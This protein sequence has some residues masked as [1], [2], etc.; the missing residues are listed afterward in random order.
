MGP[1]L[2]CGP[3]DPSHPDQVVT[4][5]RP[6]GSDAAR[7]GD[8][9]P[10][11]RGS[12][13]H[14]HHRTDRPDCHPPGRHAHHRTGRPDCHP[15][16]RV[17]SDRS[18]I[19]AAPTAR[20][21]TSPCE[22]QLLVARRLGTR[23]PEGDRNVTTP[24]DWNHRSHVPG[25]SRRDRHPGRNARSARNPS[26]TTPHAMNHHP[27]NWNDHGTTSRSSEG[28]SLPCWRDVADHRVRAAR[29]HRVG[30]TRRL[31][32]S[33]VLVE[34]G[35]Y[36][37][38]GP[39]PQSRRASRAIT[40]VRQS[41][42]IGPDAPEER[43]GHLSSGYEIRR[44]PTLPGTLVPSTI[45]AGGLNFRVRDGNGCDPSAVATEICCQLAR[46]TA[47]RGLHSEHELLR[48]RIPSPR[49]ISTGQLS[50][51]LRLHFRPINVV[52]YHG[53]YQVDP[54]GGIILKRASR[55]DA[56]SGYPVRRSPTSRALGRTTGTRE[57]RPSRSSR[58]RD[59]FPQSTFGCR[60]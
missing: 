28:W 4:R 13:R 2:R 15:P 20:T 31:R 60:G 53:P 26:A 1:G 44:R 17:R 38:D 54:V 58:T 12:G 40:P 36:P 43:C 3:D 39:E 55:L 49:P 32:R 34:A 33:W 9:N 25:R 52:V 27:T 37:P 10:S 42:R 35:P 45:G 29:R 59:S 57:L 51:L 16:G 48:G 19:D 50:A 41:S 7:C 14:A 30:G 22:R 6:D 47:P 5:D 46:R 21:P 56:F 23:A 18:P 24:N 11:A 8:P